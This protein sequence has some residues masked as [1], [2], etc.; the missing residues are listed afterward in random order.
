MTKHIDD[1]FD[2]CWDKNW[3]RCAHF[4]YLH[5]HGRIIV[6]TLILALNNYYSEPEA[7]YFPDGGAGL[8]MVKGHYS[9]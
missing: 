9:S 5:I 3:N 7:K 4:G 2:I 8:L 6:Y 1:Y